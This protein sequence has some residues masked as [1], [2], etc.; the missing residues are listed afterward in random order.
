[1]RSTNEV[2]EILETLR[3]G[4]VNAEDFKKL[5]EEQKKDEKDPFNN[6]PRRHPA[7]IVNSERP[8]NAETPPSFILDNF[9]TPNDIFFVRNHMPVPEVKEEEHVVVV[10]GEGIRRPI[11]LSVEQLKMDYEPHSI[12]AV[13]QCAGNRRNDMNDHKKVN[14]LMWTG[15]AISNAKWT[16]ARLR[17]ILLTAG[18]NP[19]DPNI[20]HVQ[21]E[22]ADHDISGQHYGASI[23]FQKAM[24][25]ETIIAYKMN[26]EDLPRDHGYPLRLVAPGIV[27]ARQVKWITGIKT[28]N[29]ESN[30]HWQKKDYR[31]FSPSVE[32]SNNVDWDSVPAI[33]G[34][35][36][37]TM[38]GYAWSGGGR[39]IIRVDVSADEGK[40]WHV[41]ELTQDPKQDL[42]TA[43]AWTF[44]KAEIPLPKDVKPGEKVVLVCKA[45]DRAYNTQPE[46]A[47]GL[48]NIRGL[49]HNAWHRIPVM[50]VD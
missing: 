13:V 38:R 19:K 34:K 9:R 11:R 23:S 35:R 29:E 10:E 46:T 12:V 28:S 21:F 32:S 41:A 1:M 26:D 7:L 22:G 8:F 25:P 43:W 18:I 30:S 14:G 27:G 48:W 24:S 6:D 16:G 4:N 39:G 47:A 49:L 42:D 20:K 15:T 44:W 40:T 2:R 17:D 5:Q 36:T 33:Q 50:I 31:A 37:I 3:I 45:T